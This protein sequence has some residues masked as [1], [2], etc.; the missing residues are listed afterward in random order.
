MP[1]PARRRRG[2]AARKP[3]A[4]PSPKRRSWTG[5]RRRV[6]TALR[7]HKKKAVAGA[8]AVTLA[9][10]AA[11]N[12][13]RNRVSVAECRAAHAD[14]GRQIAWELE[15]RLGKRRSAADAADDGP[16]DEFAGVMAD[17]YMDAADEYMDAADAYMDDDMF[18]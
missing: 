1:S 8:V 14:L 18:A 7:R 5:A 3:S 6:S 15:K 13:R 9:A 16:A 17:E 12:C 11:A 2:S 10:A 4:K